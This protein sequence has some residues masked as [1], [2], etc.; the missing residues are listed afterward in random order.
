LGG[1]YAAGSAWDGTTWNNIPT[2]NAPGVTHSFFR[3]TTMNVNIGYNIYLPPQYAT[4][5]TQRF[6][7]VYF[8]H[9]Q[10]SDENQSNGAA[11]LPS[12]LV[13][14]LDR[15]I[16]AGT[17]KAMIVVFPNGGLNSHYMDAQP[18][19]PAFDVYMIESMMINEL[20]PIIDRNYRTLATAAGRAM[21]GFSM[22]GQGCERLAFKYPQLF[23]SMYCFSPAIDDNS[24]NVMANEP[25]LM[26]NMFNNNIMLF[27]NNTAQ[28]IAAANATNINGLPIHVTIGSADSLLSVNQSMDTQLTTNG[29]THDAL[30]VV[31]GYGHDL[32]GIGAAISWANYNF[33][34]SHFP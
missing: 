33:A 16:R 11:G 32:Y 6:P 14:T 8:L 17:V 29:I 27:Q 31:N 18:R 25:A 12:A 24:S 28:N 34:S 4:N 10:P 30:Q 20:I 1:L 21:Q 5:S 3:S 9:G 2:S 13:S 19:T 15:N 7:V 22:G 23:S 26:A